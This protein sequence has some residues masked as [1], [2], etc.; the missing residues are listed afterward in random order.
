M[1]LKLASPGALK[2]KRVLVS[3]GGSG[4]GRA[5]AVAFAAEGARVAVCGR[6][7][8]KLA[9]TAKAAGGKVLVL[10]ADVGDPRA[11]AGLMESLDKEWGGLDVLVNNAGTL[12]SGPLVGY[13]LEHWKATLDTNLTGPFLLTNAALGLMKE[14]GRVV[15]ITSG[16]GFFPMSPY[17][18]YCVSKAALNMLGRAFA[19]ELAGRGIL[20]NTVDP[21]VAKTEMNSGASESPDT[22][23]AITR[24]LA[25]LPAGGPTGR[26][27]KKSGEEIEV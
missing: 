4:F 15:N 21:G 2:G 18:A 26:F 5:M 22:V 9:E 20:V 27:F 16:L 19:Q 7:A 25:S 17:N 24:T 3:G 12:K 11:A 6:R 23:V 13:P 8:G 10:A 1:A 14:G